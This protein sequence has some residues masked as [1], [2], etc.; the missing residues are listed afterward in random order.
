MPS[1]P[2][3]GK[4]ADINHQL[5]PAFNVFERIEDAHSDGRGIT[6]PPA[7]LELLV[8]LCGDT[9]NE[10]EGDVDRWNDLIADVKEHESRIIH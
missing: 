3:A 8:C 7:E 4:R 9:I 1:T 10:A 6:L 5:P 2:C